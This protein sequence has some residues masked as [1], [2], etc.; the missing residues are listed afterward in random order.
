MSLKEHMFDRQKD[1]VSQ[2]AI[3]GAACCQASRNMPIPA[4]ISFPGRILTNIRKQF[5]TLLLQEVH[6]LNTR[7]GKLLMAQVPQDCQVQDFVNPRVIGQALQLKRLRRPWLEARRPSSLLPNLCRLQLPLRVSQALSLC[8]P[9]QKWQRLGRLQF[10]K[11]RI[12]C[13]NRCEIS[14]TTP[15]PARCP[16]A[17][18]VCKSLKKGWRGLNRLA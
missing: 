6:L 4:C 2:V 18:N 14:F 10:P 13:E 11:K 9:S 7:I 5:S 12:Y 15:T 16:P 8:L 1:A 17:L 3:D